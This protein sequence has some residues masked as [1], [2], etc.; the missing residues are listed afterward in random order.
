VF[1]SV[2]IAGSAGYFFGLESEFNSMNLYAQ[3]N[4]CHVIGD[5][6]ILLVKGRGNPLIKAL[7]G[8]HRAVIFG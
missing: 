1:N 5:G 3:I 7:I 4:C 6:M 8:N 2:N